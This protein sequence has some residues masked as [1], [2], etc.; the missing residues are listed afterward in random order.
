MSRRYITL[1]PLAAFAFQAAAPA[2]ANPYDDC[3]LEH[4][5]NTQ[6]REA[7][8]AI[9]RACISKTSVKITEEK[10]TIDSAYAGTYNNGYQAVK[11]LVISATNNTVFAITEVAVTLE[12][13]QTRAVTRYMLDT[14]AGPLPNGTLVSG[15]PEP[16]FA[17]I[18]KSGASRTFLV[19][20]RDLPVNMAEFSKHFAW[21][22]VPTKGI[23]SN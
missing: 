6:T 3:I 15:P 17:Q 22:V 13:K 4:M 19:D 7:V 2:K 14:F 9:E 23:P 20:M 21:D 12:D 10:L 18:I 16:A 8:Y 11:G 5:A 1:I